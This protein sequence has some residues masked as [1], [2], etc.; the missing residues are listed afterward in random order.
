MNFIAGSRD[1][2]FRSA[3]RRFQAPSSAITW[4]ESQSQVAPAAP[5]R[6]SATGDAFEN[7]VRHLMSNLTHA[8]LK[9]VAVVDLTPQGCPIN[10]VRVVV[11]GLEGYMHHSYR[12]G[13]RALAFMEGTTAQCE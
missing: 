5:R 12:P 4:L 7:D 8:G 6:T 3:F 11:P 10:V 13:H 1:D 2:I 9:H